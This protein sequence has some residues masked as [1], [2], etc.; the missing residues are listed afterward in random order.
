MAACQSAMISKTTSRPMTANFNPSARRAECG[1]QAVLP[2]PGWRRGDHVQPRMSGGGTNTSK[3]QPIAHMFTRNGPRSLPRC[4][5]V[6]RLMLSAHRCKSA[7]NGAGNVCL[8]DLKAHCDSEHK[9]DEGGRHV[10]RNGRLA[11]RRPLRCR[12][13]GQAVRSG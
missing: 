12:A 4:A 10:A 7:T 11:P 13:H 5:I 6:M 9:M 2:A 8:V 1:C 3:S